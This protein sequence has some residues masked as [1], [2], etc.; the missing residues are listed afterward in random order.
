MIDL[1]YRY[2]EGNLVLWSENE[3]DMFRNSNRKDFTWIGLAAVSE[4][5][6]NAT[7]YNPTV[8]ACQ[9]DTQ[10]A[11]STFYTTNLSDCK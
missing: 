11:S 5:T 7:T 10:A 8:R 3:K 1:E 2:L 4:H 9:G 6:S